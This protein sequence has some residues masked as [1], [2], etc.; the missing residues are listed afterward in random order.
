M[1][2]TFTESL[3]QAP[4]DQLEKAM[5][6]ILP[7]QRKILDPMTT[8]ADPKNSF[9]FTVNGADK[10]V[11]GFAIHSPPFGAGGITWRLL[12]KVTAADGD[13]KVGA[14][15]GFFTSC[16]SHPY[17]RDWKVTAKATLF[18][19]TSSKTVFQRRCTDH[20]YNAKS[21][22]WGYAQ[23]ADM[24][25]VKA[26]CVVDNA[27]S[28][29]MDVEVTKLENFFPF[30]KF[31]S[32]LVS[33][34]ANPMKRLREGFL[35]EAMTL[36]ADVRRDAIGRHHSIATKLLR[37]DK[38]LSDLKLK[39]SIERI[40]R[41]E[42]Y[43]PTNDRMTVKTALMGVPIPKHLSRK[44]NMLPKN[45]RAD[46]TAKIVQ[47]SEGGGNVSLACSQKGVA[48][49]TDYCCSCN[50][51]CQGSRGR[52]NMSSTTSMVESTTETATTSDSG[53]SYEDDCS[54]M[55]NPQVTFTSDSM[56]MRPEQQI[57]CFEYG[58]ILHGIP[59][60]PPSEVGEPY[61]VSPSPSATNPIKMFSKHV[62]EAMPKLPETLEEMIGKRKDGKDGC[63][64]V[65]ESILRK[66]FMN[67]LQDQSDVP[68]EV[69][70]NAVGSESAKNYERIISA[71]V[72]FFKTTT[73][74][75]CR[76]TEIK[77]PQQFVFNPDIHSQLDAI[78][79]MDDCADVFANVLK[80]STKT[81]ESKR[82]QIFNDVLNAQKDIIIAL[83]D[84]TMGMKLI[85][86]ESIKLL[87][88]LKKQLDDVETFEEAT[89]LLQ[90]KRDSLK[91]RLNKI[92]HAFVFRDYERQIT[93][94]L[95]DVI[96]LHKGIVDAVASEGVVLKKK[97]SE[98]KATL[99]L[100]VNQYQ[101]CLKEINAKVAD[102]L[103]ETSAIEK[104][105]AKIKKDT[106]KT[107]DHDERL[108]DQQKLQILALEK[109]KI[110]QEVGIL[111]DDIDDYLEHCDDG[112]RERGRRFDK[113]RDRSIKAALKGEMDMIRGNEEDA[114]AVRPKLAQFLKQCLTM[115]DDGTSYDKLPELPMFEL[116]EVPP[117]L[118]GF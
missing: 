47:S 29:R 1:I 21:N 91:K 11:D 113:S 80:V 85:R 40:E 51:P 48:I 112:L 90:E 58:E 62:S 22:D 102:V 114:K 88:E 93:Y 109:F 67:I 103:R 54:N 9:T 82:P 12:L 13:G 41:G 14:C 83:Q 57:H 111:E 8:R 16:C 3:A 79:Y 94:A 60:S 71:V 19:L 68:F 55:S 105:T 101:G 70:I 49:C 56:G 36:N 78:K 73:K 84:R 26:N 116:P 27:F 59:E 107:I 96:E 115:L 37:D 104:E 38:Y 5:K 52:R 50:G 89:V 6:G 4:V 39:Q 86:G 33:R 23:F 42:N 95:E 17:H 66:Y 34:A 87:A 35:D 10:M 106:L 15:L 74:E 98:L 24:N 18:T 28:V 76:N 72:N 61:I 69:Y 2:A 64:A 99:K 20:E 46:L 92:E 117:C 43:T 63:Q 100:T 30:D 45:V 97:M 108:L 81:V 65:F 77:P 32:N 7:S 44:I 75:V 31:M 53:Y 118:I 110:E 25:D